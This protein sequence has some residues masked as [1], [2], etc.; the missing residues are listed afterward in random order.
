M[1]RCSA[2]P[3]LTTLG[4]TW[5]LLPLFVVG[6]LTLAFTTARSLRPHRP[7]M[8]NHGT[9]TSTASASS[10]LIRRVKASDPDAWERLF[11]LYTPMVY[12]WARR[13]GLRDS[14][15]SDIS[16]EVFRAVVR[17]IDDFQREQ[18]SSSFRSWL[19]AI[20]RNQIRL[21]YRQRAD[22]PEAVGGTDADVLLQQHAS[23]LEEETDPSGLTG[24]KLLVQRALRLIR[25]DFSERNWQAFWR[26]AVEGHSAADIAD[27]LDMSA[28]AVRQAKYRVLCRL[29]EELEGS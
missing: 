23:F 16:Q 15:A 5:N 12:G 13:G 18:G 4:V 27:Q 7:A 19:W 6:K 9:R 25:N 28:A 1:W 26:L 24:R 10:S 17:S 21:Y 14:D 29:R 11:Q 20:T 3:C 8:P 22:E 2:A